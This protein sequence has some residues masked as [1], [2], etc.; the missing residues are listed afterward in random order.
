MT[1]VLPGLITYPQ[2][3]PHLGQTFPAMTHC[4][5]PWLSQVGH[6]MLGTC[7]Y[8]AS[9]KVEKHIEMAECL[10]VIKARNKYLDLTCPLS[11]MIVDGGLPWK[12][13]AALVHAS[14][15]PGNRLSTS[16]H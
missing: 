16:R 1:E 14:G 13:S 6:L 4:S 5:M 2:G 12:D 10:N 9:A 3:V 15:C 8:P 7:R 11:A